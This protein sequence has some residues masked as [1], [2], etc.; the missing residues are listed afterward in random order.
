MTF[1][2]SLVALA[3]LVG[4][5]GQDA[6]YDGWTVEAGDCDDNDN[7]VYPGGNELC[8]G[9]DNDCNDQIDDALAGKFVFYVDADG[10]G[11]GATTLTQMACVAPEGFVEN[12]SD[13]RDEGEGAADFNP[14]AEETCDG[15]D[16]N[17]NGEIDENAIDATDF[18]SDWDQ[19][20][21]GSSTLEVLACTAP[22]G[23]ITD[24]SDCND[25]DPFTNP[26]SDEVCDFVDNNCDGTVDED[27]AVDAT[28]FY[29]DVDGDG[30]GDLES[31]RMACWL[32]DGFSAESTDCNDSLGSVNPGAEEICRDG[33]D[34]NCDDSA[35]QCSFES[36]D[37][38]AN[39][40]VNWIGENTYDYMGQDTTFVGDVDGDGYDD[41]VVGMHQADANGTW[42]AGTAWLIY[43]ND[44]YEPSAD[45]LPITSEAAGFNGSS[46]YGYL[47]QSV[48]PAGD[49]DGDGYDDFLVGA[50]GVS[51]SA[52][53]AI[54]IYGGPTRMEGRE[55]AGDV[56]VTFS[57]EGRYEYFGGS[58]WGGADLDGDGNSEIF[59]GARGHNSYRG[60]VFMWAGS[61][62]RLDG[63][64]DKD[65]ADAYWEGNNTY[66][67]MGSYAGA[68]GGGDFDGDG[69][70]DL[71]IGAER[72][73][74]YR[75]AAYV[76]WGDG[77]T[78]PAGSQDETT[79]TT[80]TGTESYRYF[81]RGLGSAGDLND[82]GYE[83]IG[84][85]CYAC[86]NYGGQ[87]FVFFGDST[88][89]GD[90]NSGDADVTISNSE[91]SAYLG[92]YRPAHGDYNGDGIDDVVVGS[93]RDTAGSGSYNGS[94]WILAG[95]A[96][97]GGEYDRES[98][99]K[100]VAGPS[101]SYGYFGSG[102]GHGDFN[103][104]G[105]TDLVGSAYGSNSYKGNLYLFEGTSL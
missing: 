7:L 50:Y 63:S 53:E 22:E 70:D 21:Y 103:G 10:D 82:D 104:D 5:A 89:I 1:R 32:P 12:A 62:T 99:T 15:E 43:G 49:V 48:G 35:N 69:N 96:A 23:Y 73:E 11:Y 38:V 40:T 93:Y 101:G 58:V 80:I 90:T 94:M 105:Y 30:F 85:G 92:Q 25:F 59:I 68:I 87:F 91:R 34:N 77:S 88:Q 52:G 86:N 26:A 76:I 57:G 55:A 17:C 41:V 75:G 71:L 29:A 19:D 95:G 66:D 9:I 54:L 61:S 24:K 74:S 78:R 27:S 60:G 44:G 20:G 67:Y 64:Y 14:R 81:G 102:V 42:S 65:D 97:V 28:E 6:D 46:Q 98:V 45:S 36:W 79:G 33:V 37:S 3:L 56:G 83:D 100:V 31:P 2:T 39:A 84:V 18:H 16:Q 51:S 72:A 47:G 13:C 4:C 8:D